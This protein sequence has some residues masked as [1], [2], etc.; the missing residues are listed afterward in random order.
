MD[1]W[2]RMSHCISYLLKKEMKFT[3]NLNWIKTY[4]YTKFDFFTAPIWVT[5]QR[6]DNEVVF[7]VW[8]FEKK[9]KLHK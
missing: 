7:I 6:S 5:N 4:V 1:K 9:I 2:S 8:I 3:W